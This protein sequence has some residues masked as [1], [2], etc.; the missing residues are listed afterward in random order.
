[1]IMASESALPLRLAAL[2]R[3]ARRRRAATVAWLVAPVAAVAVALPW[4]AWGAVAGCGFG[5]A[6][7]LAWAALTLRELKV[8]D[9]RWLARRLNESVPG[10][11]DSIDLALGTEHSAPAGAGLAPLQRA[12]LEARIRDAELPDLRAA[13]PWRALCLAWAGAALLWLLVSIASAPWDLHGLRQARAPDA[14]ATG[15]IIEAS[16]RYEPPAYTG[17]GS[18]QV[19][20]LDAKVPAGSKVSF[21][22]RLRGDPPGAALQ[23]LDGS[24]LS[25][26]RDGAVWRGERVLDR[27]TLYRLVLDD[28]RP[29]A[30]DALHRIDV[31]ADRPPEVIVHAPDRTLN[32][33][34]AGQKTWDLAF[35]ASDDYG[36]GAAELSISLAQGSGENIKTTQQS[37]ALDGK[38]DARHRTYARTLDLDALGFSRGDD[39]IVR[40]SVADNHPAPPNRTQSASFILRW[41]APAEAASTAM[42]GLVQKTMPAYFSSERQLIIDTEALQ[43]ERPRLEAGRFAA[44]SDELG[45]EQ[46]MLRLRYGEFLGEEFESAAEHAAV[47]PAASAPPTAAESPQPVSAAPAARQAGA[48]VEVEYGH[49]HDKPEAATLLDPDTRRLLKAALDEMWQAELHL[50]VGEPDQALPYEY[51]ALDYIKQVQQAE[52]IYLARAGVALPQDDAGRRLS[53]DRKGLEDRSS[54]APAAMPEDSPV[55]MAW[56]RLSAGAT[57][58]LPAL[59]RWAEQHQATLPDALSVVAAAERLRRDPDCAGCRAELR[60]LLWPLLPRSATA[61]SPRRQ[62]DA[63]GTA[64]ERALAE[65]ADAPADA[66]AAAPSSAAP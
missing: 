59:T 56:A 22:L 41:P 62:A 7:A 1:M 44:R 43:S 23:F 42:A 53:G 25:L 28:A 60:R 46:K 32:L 36:L 4:H 34:A 11:E 8:Y 45:V 40:L 61:L 3:A 51:K 64:Y 21:T 48:A 10:F 29:R 39:L 18:R 47:D 14:A 9:R 24:R 38:G 6:A 27:S 35:E 31:I 16:L 49:V 30:T 13:Y 65:Q 54:A 33:L 5:A 20:A 2:R 58:D 15:A 17:L 50:R 55:A 37:I 26:Q 57:P 66:P 19:S 52:R 12:R 63:E